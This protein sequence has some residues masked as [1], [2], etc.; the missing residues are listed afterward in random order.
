MPITLDGDAARLLGYTSE[1]IERFFK[2][3]LENLAEK[4]GQSIKKIMEGIRFWYNGYQFA[5]EGDKVYNPFSVLL[6]LADGIFLN[7]WFETGT[8]S[9]LTHLMKRQS[10]LVFDIEGSEVNIE[11]TRSYDLD[12]MQLLPLLWQTGY[13]TIEKYDVLAKNYTLAFPN[14]E[15][16][17]SFL[18][19]FM[20]HL[21]D[22]KISMIANYS[23][24]LS[25]AL[26]KNDVDL[27]FQTLQVFFAHIP[28]T[29][30]LPL[31][32]YYQSIFY[33]ILN[34]LGLPT[35]A[36]VET[37]NGRIDAV[38]ETATHYYIIEF[39]LHDSAQAALQQIEAKQYYQRYLQNQKQVVLIGAH[40]DTEKR[41][42]ESW[43]TKEISI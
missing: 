38:I 35:H 15:V 12:Q 8:P 21:T 9:F 32:K 42:L 18:R 43:I 23:L 30:Q 6:Y 41:D 2:P 27:F 5:H 17:T 36:E 25:N 24:K 33:V 16:R 3:Y 39:K 1:E 29:L 10:Y 37:N 31:E 13:L 14:E 28:Y 40:F 26:R 34:V 11:E 4:K 7:Y 22:T 19:Y 20:R